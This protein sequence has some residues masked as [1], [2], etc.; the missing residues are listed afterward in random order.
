METMTSDNGWLLLWGYSLAMLALV[1]VGT[2]RERSA[3]E[4]LVANR[5][6]GVWAGA[7]S[8]AATWIWAPAIFVCSQKSYQQ[9]L[10]GI[11]WFTVPN[12]LC[13]F[14]FVPVALRA[15]RLM[16]KSYSL[17][18]FIWRRFRGN[19][20]AHLSFLFISIGITI[21]GIISNSLAGGML[22]HSLSGVDQ[23]RAIVAFAAI[24]LFYSVWRGLP[25][26]IVTDVV[27]MCLILALALILVPWTLVEAGGWS[28]VAG[29]LS[30]VGGSQNIFDPWIAYSFGIPA[31]IGLLSGPICDQMFY[32]RAMA[33][34]E[35]SITRTFIYAGLLFA[36]VPIILSIFGFIG[37]NPAV[38]SELPAGDP[39]LIGVQVVSHFLPRWTLVGFAIMALCGLSSTLDSAYCAAGSLYSVDLYR[40]YFRPTATDQQVLRASKVGMLLIGMAGTAVA[41][42]PGVQLLWIF[43]V[44]GVLAAAGAVPAVLSLFWRRVTARGVFLGTTL[45]VLAGLPLSIYANATASPHLVVLA[46][47]ATSVIS[48]VVTLLDGVGCLGSV[49]SLPMAN[50]EESTESNEV[51]VRHRG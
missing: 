7:L 37:A 35:G 44:Y 3:E 41:I 18:D 21:T 50:E 43:L 20:A 4:Y 30:G 24:A 32:Q 16:P 12:V 40:R 31:T 36:A 42:L 15:R 2:R 26:S 10:A 29:G 14:T 48:L 19:R 25:G 33:T 9:G 5:Q 49:V 8:M 11:F 45:S 17:P 23:N 39:Q 28:T 38:S 1:V 47:V 13:F 46:T 34:R 6:V 27:Q 51:L 22:L